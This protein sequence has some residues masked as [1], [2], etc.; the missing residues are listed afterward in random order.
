MKYI[1]KFPILILL[2][3]VNTNLAISQQS[4]LSIYSSSK[5]YIDSLEIDGY[6]IGYVK[7]N[8][9]TKSDKTEDL[10][11]TFL[12]SHKYIISVHGSESID[13]LSIVLYN[14]ENNDWQQENSGQH[15]KMSNRRTSLIFE[16]K[17]SRDILVKVS[18]HKFSDNKSSGRYFLVIG[19]KKITFKKVES[20][21]VTMAIK[22]RE[23]IEYNVISKT[24][25]SKKKK[26]FKSKLIVGK[27]EVIHDYFTHKHEYTV[28]YN[29]TSI[30]D[31]K[32]GCVELSLKDAASKTYK[33]RINSI[34]KTIEI[35]ELPQN[36]NAIATGT[37]YYY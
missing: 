22:Q 31:R 24:Y 4:I 3:I 7:L 6:T 8:V 18:A 11:Y 14:W 10:R 30:D 17:E 15:E 16:P 20:E 28:F 33:M 36:V 37:R 21:P 2:V 19:N 29:T 1:R 25:K 27:D 32:K 9:L 35:I 26:P 5:A 13:G 34:D 23:L 12:G